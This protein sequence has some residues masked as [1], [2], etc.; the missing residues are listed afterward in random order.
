MKNKKDYLMAAYVVFLAFAVV[1]RIWCLATNHQFDNWNNI[2]MAVTIASYS[3]AYA[4]MYKSKRDL[5]IDS[6]Y[7]DSVLIERLED[8]KILVEIEQCDAGYKNDVMLS[9]EEMINKT[10]KRI[11]ATNKSIDNCNISYGAFTITGFLLFLI[12][13]LTGFVTYDV[14][15]LEICTVIAFFNILFTDMIIDGRRQK[16]EK[17]YEENNQHINNLI[18][19]QKHNALVSVTNNK[20]EENDGQVENGD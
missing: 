14:H 5:L 18:E 13:A 9:S 15:S 4:D 20:S 7:K 2:I 19:T 1:Y 12:I 10:K 3:F 6:S 8:F 11:N 17:L 16:L